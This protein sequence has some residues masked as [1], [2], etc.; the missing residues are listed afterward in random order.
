[1]Q[2]AGVTQYLTKVQGMPCKIK[3]ELNKQIRKS[4]WNNDKLDTVNQTQ[5]YANHKKGGKKVVS[6]LTST[7]QSADNDEGF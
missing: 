4:M 5:M 6:G 1:M 3:S 2:V 7:S